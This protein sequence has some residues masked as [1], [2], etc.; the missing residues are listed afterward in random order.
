MVQLVSL[1]FRLTQQTGSTKETRIC[2]PLHLLGSEAGASSQ[3][4]RTMIIQLN[5]FYF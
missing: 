1:T 2:T 3:C 4:R 5:Q